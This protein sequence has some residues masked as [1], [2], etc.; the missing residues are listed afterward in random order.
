MIS[1]H[2]TTRCTKGISI[3]DR[4]WQKVHCVIESMLV[5]QITTNQFLN[6]LYHPEEVLS[7]SI[8]AESLYWS[9]IKVFIVLN[10][11][12]IENFKK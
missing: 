5:Q 9:N 3:F 7:L 8:H 1:M 11:F 10:V 6:L 4:S 2:E 12:K